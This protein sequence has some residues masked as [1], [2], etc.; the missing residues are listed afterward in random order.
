MTPGTW[1]RIS[2]LFAE[3]LERPSGTREAFVAELR[4]RD[5]MAAAEVA[6]LL[7]AH[8]RPGEFL[9]ELPGGDEPADLTGR[10]IGSYRLVRVIGAGG[11]GVVY[12]AERNDGAFARRV[13]VKL[14]SASFQQSRE[15]LLHER[16]PAAASARSIS[17]RFE[18]MRVGTGRRSSHRPSQSPN[19]YA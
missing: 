12:L 1:S 6:S 18:I 2:D 14:L 17:A 7:E 19:G 5:A 11:T 8:A 13:A 16:R 9:P 10:V 4:Q 3:A 15:R